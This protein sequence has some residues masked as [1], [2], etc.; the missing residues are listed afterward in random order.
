[1]FQMIE[2][3]KGT[4]HVHI[5]ADEAHAKAHCIIHQVTLHKMSD[6]R[7]RLHLLIDHRMESD[8][9]VESLADTIRY[10]S[11]VAEE[12][13]E[14][15]TKKR[16]TRR[17]TATELLEQAD[18]SSAT[19]RARV[20]DGLA[21]QAYTL[22][23]VTKLLREGQEIEVR[24]QVGT[25]PAR[26]VHCGEGRIEIEIENGHYRGKRGRIDMT[27]TG[28]GATFDKVILPQQH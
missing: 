6:A 21:Y 13:H 4:Y 24:T 11:P 18:A 15:K 20:I 10:G 3:G 7:G 14:M 22:G 27:T 5:F 19:L 23:G 25:F 16:R 26:I 8:S 9:R 17:R 2:Q 28:P 12:Y 1:M